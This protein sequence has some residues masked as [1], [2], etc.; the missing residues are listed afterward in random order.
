MVPKPGMSGRSSAVTH[1]AGRSFTAG[2]ALSARRPVARH[3]A[4][5]ASRPLPS[6]KRNAVSW[7]IDGVP[8]IST[9]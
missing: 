8:S 2:T 9:R 1:P 4:V 5:A 6:V 3:P 7:V